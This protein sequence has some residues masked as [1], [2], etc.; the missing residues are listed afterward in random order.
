ML[1][2][3]YCLLRKRGEIKHSMIILQHILR[4]L[5]LYI[6]FNYV[7]PSFSEINHVARKVYSFNRTYLNL[8]IVDAPESGI[9]D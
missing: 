4:L 1:N 8:E 6:D 7:L 5:H 9:I 2:H 3:H